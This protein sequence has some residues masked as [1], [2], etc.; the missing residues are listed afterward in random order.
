MENLLCCYLDRKVKRYREQETRA[1]GYEKEKLKEAQK[2]EQLV[3][4]K[5]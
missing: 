5:R 1:N 2:K 4:R 3:T